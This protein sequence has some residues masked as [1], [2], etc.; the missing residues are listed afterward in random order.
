M[1]AT[2][3]EA[4][5]RRMTDPF[6]IVCGYGQSGR[7][8]VAA[9]DEIGFATVVLERD[10]ERARAHLVLAHAQPGRHC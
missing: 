4:R 7:R 8:L 10:P 1:A 5:V 6:F 9:L 2:A 3:F